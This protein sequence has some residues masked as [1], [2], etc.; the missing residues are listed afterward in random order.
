MWCLRNHC[1]I[2]DHEDLRLFCCEN[3]T[4]LALNI[5]S[6]FYVR[7]K[8]EVQSHSLEC[9]YPI[10]QTF[11]KTFSADLPWHG[12]QKSVVYKCEGLFLFY[13]IDLYVFLCQLHSI[14]ITIP[15]RSVLKLG[16]VTPT[17]FFKI[18]F[19][20]FG[21]LEMFLFSLSGLQRDLIGHI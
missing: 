5:L 18:V 20:Y 1:I 13:C 16:S 8:V 2:Q 6:N 17:L 14:S 4:V 12:C 21:L 7:C 19:D 15:L 9:G 10:V 3:S 11:E